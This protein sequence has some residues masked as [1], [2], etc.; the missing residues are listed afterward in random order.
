MYSFMGAGACGDSGLNPVVSSKMSKTVARPMMLYG[1][2]VIGVNPADCLQSSTIRRL[3][4]LPQSTTIMAVC[5]L[6]GIR[7]TEQELDL[8][9][10]SASC[11][12]ALWQGF[13]GAWNFM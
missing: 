8:R 5:S 12:S 11:F 2:K 4:S 6:L 1:F 9:K 13:I 3:Q 7:P 10:M